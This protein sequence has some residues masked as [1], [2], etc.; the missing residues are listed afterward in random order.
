MRFKYKNIKD[1]YLKNQYLVKKLLFIN[2][3][4][5]S[6]LAKL[7]LNFFLKPIHNNRMGFYSYFRGFS[8]SAC[9]AANLAI[10]TRNG[11][12]ET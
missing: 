10:G 12:H 7:S 6:E 3:L 2:I 4:I 9:A 11:E 1:S 5:S 8:I